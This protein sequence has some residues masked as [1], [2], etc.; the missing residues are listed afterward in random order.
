MNR[1]DIIKSILDKIK[2]KTYLEIGV[3]SGDCFLNINN[4]E[5]KIGV[6][7][8]PIHDNIKG[9]L[10]ENK[11]MYYQNTSDEF[12]NNH[13]H[14]LDITGIDVA[15]IDGLHEYGQVLKD[16]ENCLKYLNK[17]GIIVMHDCNPPEEFIAIPALS[18][19]DAK[20][21]SLVKGLSWTG[22][23]C[24]DV[25]KSVVYLRS[26]KTDVNIFV[27]NCDWG[28][29]IITNAPSSKSLPYTEEAIKNLQ[30]DYLAEH[31]VE[32]LNLK[33]EDYL[34]EFLSKL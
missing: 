22:E 18:L 32:L 3:A 16:I 21:K 20:Q 33:P 28:V 12:F 7:P 15:F 4:A 2:G 13:S 6:D 30:Y 17:G 31:R 23:W 14:I 34:Y 24:G 1:I 8:A 19:E 29:G 25:W 26:M 27:L 5:N 10:I 11:V 9:T